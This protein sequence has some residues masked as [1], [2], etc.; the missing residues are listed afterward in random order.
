MIQGPG[1]L[2]DDMKP[3]GGFRVQINDGRGEKPR[4]IGGFS[5]WGCIG[6]MDDASLAQRL[7]RVAEAGYEFFEGTWTDGEKAAEAAKM[8]EN[9]E[10]RLVLQAHFSDAGAIDDVLKVAERLDAL[11]VNCHIR[12]PW[13]DELTA[14]RLADRVTASAEAAGVPLMVET[15]RGTITQDVLRTIRWADRSTCRFNL[16][17]SHWMVAGELG[18]GPGDDMIE[19]LAPLVGRV[20]MIHGRISNGQQVQVSLDTV[21]EETIIAYQKLWAT[22]MGHWKRNARAGD[23]FLFEPE[24]GPPNYALRDGAGNEF[25]DRWAESLELLKLARNAW[26]AVK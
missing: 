23:V 15:H 19:R 8:A 16:D 20:G 5:N 1:T 2:E 12:D 9:L 13:M 22:A 17:V 4:L 24:L 3:A 26:D 14:A 11:A 10:L 25:S 6:L 18:S 21:S 7:G